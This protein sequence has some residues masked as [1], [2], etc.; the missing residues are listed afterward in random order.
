MA[1]TAKPVPSSDDLAAALES[2]PSWRGFNVWIVGTAPL[3]CHAWSEKARQEMLGK[4]VKASRTKEAR[5]PHD[6]F[7]SSIYHLPDGSYG[8]PA[9][10]VKQSWTGTADKSKGL[11]KSGAVGANASIYVDT[12]TL[13]KQR[14]AFPGAVSDLP[15]LKVYGGEPEMREDPVRLAGKTASF[16]YRAQFWPWAIRVTGRFNPAVLSNGQLSQLISD[17]GQAVGIG[18][19]RPARNG[20]FGTYRMANSAQAKAWDDFAAGNGPCPIEVGPE[21][22]ETIDLVAAE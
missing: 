16:T 4:Q 2:V 10:A 17:G 21:V 20:M 12:P 8:F 6:D 5:D 13:A 9:M 1:K 22:V 14:T 19:W 7:I 18:D 15:I 3:I 11:A